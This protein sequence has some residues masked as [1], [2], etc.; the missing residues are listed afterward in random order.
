MKLNWRLC[1]LVETDCL[2]ES[3]P[4]SVILVETDCLY[5]IIPPSVLFDGNRLSI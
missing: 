3:I 4:P 2:Y 1:Y 5:E